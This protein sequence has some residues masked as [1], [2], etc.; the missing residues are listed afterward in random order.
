MRWFNSLRK[1]FIYN[2]GELIQAFGA[3]FFTSSWVPQP[4]DAL[5][6]MKMGSGKALQSYA[7][8]Y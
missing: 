8:R 1:G 6:F 2:F 5:L 4:I 7:D 3:C